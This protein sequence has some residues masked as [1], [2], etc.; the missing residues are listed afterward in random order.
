MKLIMIFLIFS[1]TAILNF[2]CNTTEPLEDNLQP[3]RRDYVWSVDTL[4][5]PFTVLSRIWGSSPT[6]V[7]A[8]G[9]GG[10][11]DE[12]IY[13]FDGEGWNNDGISRPLAPISVFGFSK[14]N[15]WLGSRGEIWHYDGSNIYKHTEYHIPGYQFSG[16]ENIRGDSPNNIFAV[17]YADSGNVKKGNILNYNGTDWKIVDIKYTPEHF[18]DVYKGSYS[19]NN[20]FI[21]SLKVDDFGTDTSKIYEFDGKNL[22][23]IYSGPYDFEGR[24]TINEINNTIY[25]TIGVKIFSYINQQ[26]NLITTI[27]NQSFGLKTWGRNQNDLILRMYDGIAHYNG[28]DIKYLYTFDNSGISIT[29]AAIFEEDVF[30]MAYDFSKN[31]NLVF[32]GKLKN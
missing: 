23:E 5:I 6:D 19:S 29:G 25:L 13:R 26:L 4:N 12:T 9:P 11:K 28:T 1:L 14:N 8:I 10:A 27:N 2:S 31:L 32:R 22:K 15:V 18:I 20:F 16:I 24:S 21:E 3:G 30:I 17:G 7:W